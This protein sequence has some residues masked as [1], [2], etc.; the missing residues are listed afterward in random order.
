MRVQADL[1]AKLSPLLA[2]TFPGFIELDAMERL[3]GGASQETYR[4]TLRTRK[5]PLLLALRRAAGG[6]P[7]E[8]SAEHPGLAVEAELMLAAARAGVPEPEIFRVLSPEEGLGPGFL[9]QWL[10]G[11]TLGSKIVKSPELDAVRPRLAA[12]CG[13]V[14]GR[15][16]GIDLAATALRE[17]LVEIGP[18]ACVNQTWARYKALQTPQPMID[19]TARWLLANLPQ[20]YQPALV[21]GDFRN[22]N[23]MVDGRRGVVAVLDWELAHVGDPHRDIGWMLTHSWRFGRAELPVGGFGQLASFLEGY[24]RTSGREVDPQAVK[25]WQVFGSFWWSVGCLG[26]AEQYRTGPDQSVERPA[27]G[28]RSSECQM[29]CVNLLIPGSVALVSP[30]SP[31]DASMMP[32]RD[33]LLASVIDFLQEEVVPAT[34]GRTQ[35][36]ARVARNSLDIVSRELALGTAAGHAEFSRLACVLAVSADEADLQALRWRLVNELRGGHWTLDAPELMEHLRATV[37]NQL[38]I[39]QP[40]YPALRA[41]LAPPARALSNLADDSH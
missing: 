30:T 17:K 14:L 13:E 4:L 24:A 22:G 8:I 35:F 16:H 26:M 28:R 37:V 39:D 7:A 25:F 29:D 12:Q 21:H 5:G 1:Q 23:I 10:D 6:L 9:M 15:I 34:E 3:S 33:E 11:I 18:E 41:A 27:V 40:R 31:V 36:L 2:E 20:T 19:Y 38:N 32:H